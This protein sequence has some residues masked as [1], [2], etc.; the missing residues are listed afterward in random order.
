M[1]NAT[2]VPN[3]EAVKT[4]LCPSCANFDT[5]VYV[6]HEHKAVWE[7]EMIMPNK[8]ANQAFPVSGSHPIMPLKSETN[9]TGLLPPFVR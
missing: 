5:C 3:Q 2:L 9:I 4:G 1:L 6:H 7:C 8:E